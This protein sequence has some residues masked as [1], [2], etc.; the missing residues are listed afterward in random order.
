[1]RGIFGVVNSSR[2]SFTLKEPGG[3]EPDVCY[4]HDKRYAAMF[5]GVIYNN[6]ELRREPGLKDYPFTASS[7]AE[8]FLAAYMQWGSDCLRRLNGMFAVAVW[9]SAEKS[10]FL[11]RDRF[12]AKPLYWRLHDGIFFFSSEIAP[13]L[14]AIARPR[15]DTGAIAQ[16]LQFGYVPSPLCVFEGIERFPA[17]HSAIFADG[18]IDMRRWRRPSF[19]SERLRD[20]ARLLDELDK[21]LETIVARELPDDVPAGVFLSGG[22][23]SSLVAAYAAKRCPE[24]PSFAMS[25]EEET[26]DESHDAE[27]VAKH[28]RLPHKQLRLSRDELSQTFADVGNTLDEPFADSTVLPLLALSRFARK[29]VNTVLTGWG[30]DEIFMGYPTL[31][32]HRIARLYQ[33]LPGVIGKK[34]IPALVKMLPVSDKYLSFEFK[35]RKFLSGAGLPPER[36]HLAWMGYFSEGELAELFLPSVVAHGGIWSAFSNQIIAELESKE[37]MDRILELDLRLFLE[38]NGLFQAD[39]MTAAA[40]LEARVPLLNPDLV[41][42]VHGLDWRVRMPGLELKPLLRNL[43][44]RYLPEAI[45]RKP[46]KGFGPPTSQWIRGALRGEVAAALSPDRIEAR[47]FFRSSKVSALLADHMERRTDNGRKIWA[48]VSL[49][50]WLERFNLTA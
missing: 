35:M 22:I 14:A 38:G 23:D 21:R 48:L 49:Q 6:A 50:L 27:M 2:I 16:Y 8:T 44:R 37:E 9:D 7:G 47:G 40:A 46:K 15:P 25:F 30:G 4:S 28:L 26:H 18:R 19:G 39:R 43:G 12:G 42:W 31:K 29:D 24:I 1:M 5:D 17:G 11:A 13:L 34:I 3:G 10:L 36:R 32:A 45:V 20:A 41:D 33:M